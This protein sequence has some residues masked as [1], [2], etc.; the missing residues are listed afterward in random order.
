MNALPS[1][2]AGVII[3]EPTIHGDSRGWFQETYRENVLAELGMTDHFVQDN[4]SR[5]QRGVLRGMHVQ[6]GD[7][8]QA[9]L[10]RCAW[11][12]IWDVV[13][14]LRRGSPTFGRWEAWQLDDERGLQV[15][16]PV[17]CAHG[18]LVLSDVADVV[19]RCSNYYDPAS[20]YVLSYDDPE[21]AIAWPG[22]DHVVSDRDAAGLALAD[23]IP[24]LPEYAG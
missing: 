15:Y 18:F 1:K 11:G 5:S 8:P 2:L 6:L 20:E 14:D 7:A 21:V 22:D 23:L 12:S 9:K 19:Y 13:V 3:L 10:V 4:H 17:G 16:C 24:V